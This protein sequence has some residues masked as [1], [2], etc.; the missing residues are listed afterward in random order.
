MH[1]CPAVILIGARITG[2]QFHHV[3]TGKGHP[4]TF[5]HDH[6]IALCDRIGKGCCDRSEYH[7]NPGNDPGQLC[8]PCKYSPGSTRVDEGLQDRKRDRGRP[9]RDTAGTVS[10][11]NNGETLR[12][13]SIEEC[14]F[15]LEHLERICCFRGCWIDGNDADAT[16]SDHT[17]PAN[18]FAVI[19]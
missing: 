6:R 17:G 9:H 16:A 1:P 8:K 7:R 5:E 3:R 13:R 12:F 18:Q 2:H 14:K 11:V 19:S 15:L 10:Q 4:G